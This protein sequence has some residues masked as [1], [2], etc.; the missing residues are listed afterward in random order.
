MKER[1]E[2]KK[3]RPEFNFSGYFLLL[4]FL[5]FTSLGW[6]HLF[7][8]HALDERAAARAY[9]LGNLYEIH[10][11]DNEVLAEE[12]GK[13]PPDVLLINKPEI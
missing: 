5:F 6:L 9:L 11:P 1:E 8:I 3:Q 12:A 2:G 13:F 7:E 4:L 10:N